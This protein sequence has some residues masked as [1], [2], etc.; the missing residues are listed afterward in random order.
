MYHHKK[1]VS[2]I[3]Q[4]P[5]SSASI[6][7]Q[8]NEHLDELGV[9]PDETLGILLHHPRI[10]FILPHHTHFRNLLHYSQ[11]GEGE[12]LSWTLVP[13]DCGSDWQSHFTWRF[14]CVW[15]HNHMVSSV[16][17]NV[18]MHSSRCGNV[19]ICSSLL[20][21]RSPLPSPPPTPFTYKPNEK[22]CGACTVVREHPSSRQ[23]VRM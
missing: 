17:V 15:E 22:R 16:R 11:T 14:P 1:R 10:F 21:Q 8:H 12:G 9:C 20:L 4:C 18:M 7:C 5:G 23:C 19:I 13:D 3:P 2:Q 6:D